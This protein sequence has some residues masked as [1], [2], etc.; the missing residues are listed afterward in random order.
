MDVRCRTTCSVSGGGAAFATLPPNVSWFQRA[1]DAHIELLPAIPTDL[2]AVSLTTVGAWV[3]VGGTL[4]AREL[5]FGDHR[6]RTSIACDFPLVCALDAETAALVDARTTPGRPNAW[7]IRADG[8]RVSEFDVGDAVN[9]LAAVGERLVVTHF[10]EGYGN[11]L[12]GALVFDRMGKLLLDYRRD[13]AGALDIVDCY[14]VGPVGAT[15]VLLNIYPDFP[16]AEVDLVSRSQQVWQVPEVVHGASA[17]SADGASVFF[18][19]PYA[20]K[21]GVYVWRRGE[22]TA[23]RVGEFHAPLEGLTGGWFLGRVG[24]KVARLR[25]PTTLD[26]DAR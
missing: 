14:A 15:S 21:A 5:F 24:G 1:K 12:H 11:P 16:L 3:G 26:A 25:F 17:V 7:I 13:V 2:E 23:S 10:D 8:E 4:Q 20:D 22:R 19:R 9:S 6:V 18:H